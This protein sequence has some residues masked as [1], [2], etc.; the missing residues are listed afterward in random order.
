M[1]KKPEGEMTL[2]SKLSFHISGT[3]EY[4]IAYT[5]V[6]LMLF[7]ECK[8]VIMISNNTGKTQN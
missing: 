2:L 7:V 5:A 6:S 4:H 8:H 1:G 3:E